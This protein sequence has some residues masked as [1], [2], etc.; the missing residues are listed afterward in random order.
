MSKQ[1]IL[2]VEDDENLQVAIVHYLEDEGYNVLTAASAAEAM[3]QVKEN[4]VHVVLLD[5][6]LPD[7]SGLQILR[8]IN[9]LTEAR[10]IIVS[11]KD[12]TTDRIVG[13][14]MGA[15][16]YITK[17]FEMRELYAR[18]KAVLRRG[19]AEQNAP[20]TKP[21]DIQQISFDCWI[22]DRDRYEVFTEDGRA[23]GLTTAEFKLLDRLSASAHRV[24]SRDQLCEAVLGSEYE[25]YDRAIDIHVARLRK[26][27]GEDPRTPRLIKT[28]RGVGYMF[29]AETAAY[30]R[31]LN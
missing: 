12:D 24:L 3:T 13:L 25:A 26:K 30:K 22:L 8:E 19:A 6:A 27:L 31:P 5:L 14:E 4:K 15:D 7:Q 10:I 17:P 16:D 2:S 1:T 28:I 23:A 21:Q 9:D 18:I 11:G 29:C 20:E